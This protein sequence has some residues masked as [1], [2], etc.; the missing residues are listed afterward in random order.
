MEVWSRVRYYIV[1]PTLYYP[2]ILRTFRGNFVYV[3]HL[4][5]EADSF[6]WLDTVL[7]GSF[8]QLSRGVSS[9]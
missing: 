6:V 9:L 1:S 5:F 8:Y 2:K 4:K 3:M 7:I